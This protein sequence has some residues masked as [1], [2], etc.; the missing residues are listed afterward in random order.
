MGVS[1]VEQQPDAILQGE[2][3]NDLN[4]CDSKNGTLGNTRMDVQHLWGNTCGEY[5]KD[6]MFASWALTSFDKPPHSS[7]S[8]C[9]PLPHWF[10]HSFEG[11]VE[12][13]AL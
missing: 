9:Q 3:V 10:A 13:L 4:P 6:K 12:K 11:V 5:T 1:W 8:R 2:E 7:S